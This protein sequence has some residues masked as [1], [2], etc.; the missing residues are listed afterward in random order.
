MRVLLDTNILIS[1]LLDFS[2]KSRI[3]KIADKGILGKYVI[4]LP[5]ELINEFTNKVLSKKYLK[6]KIKKEEPEGFVRILLEIGEIIPTIKEEIPAVTRGPK[7]DYLLA[8]ALV[9]EADFL[10]SGDKDLLVL[11]KV[12]GVKMV[13]V[14]EFEKNFD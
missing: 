14:K 13:D 2:G 11:K 6:N 7:D 1:Y 8:Y 5:E 4:L 9:G 12:G 3:S 10:V